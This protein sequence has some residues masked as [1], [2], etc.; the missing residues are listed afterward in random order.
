[1]K[2]FDNTLV[3]GPILSEQVK[4]IAVDGPAGSGKSTIC[5]LAGKNLGWGYVSTGLLYR[6]I[7][8]LAEEKG[9]DLE[10]DVSLSKLAT[11]FGEQ[12]VWQA[13][14]NEIFF[15][16]RNLTNLLYTVKSGRAAS[17]VAKQPECR[18]ALLPVQRKMVQFAKGGVLFDGRDVGT[19][20]FPEADCKIFMTASLEK[21]ALRRLRQLEN[22]GAETSF[23]VEQ[24]MADI[25]KRDRQDS[26]RG[27]APLI[28]AKDAIYFDTSDLD[29]DQ[30]VE[31]ML[32]IIKTAVGLHV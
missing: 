18:A 22:N 25:E 13:E 14:T 17:K 15:D 9:I 28:Q 31:K 5:R 32:H 11:T 30:S 24:L 20:V 26:G 19:V 16:D 21:R 6:A 7:G 8:I 27:V 10:D 29:L 4:I 2:S 23:S 12:F 3:R 1:M